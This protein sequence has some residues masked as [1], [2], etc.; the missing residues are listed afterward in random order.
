MNV[1]HTL[2]VNDWYPVAIDKLLFVGQ[3]TASDI[4]GFV[5]IC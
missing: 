5:S 3:D 2:A 1:D 4:S